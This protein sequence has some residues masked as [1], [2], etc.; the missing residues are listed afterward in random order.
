MVVAHG[1]FH[2]DGAM[3]E[4]MF[5]LI[6][7]P[8]TYDARLSTIG[9]TEGYQPRGWWSLVPINTNY[10]DM[11]PSNRALKCDIKSPCLVDDGVTTEKY[12]R[13]VDHEEWVNTKIYQYQEGTST[14]PLFMQAEIYVKGPK[15]TDFTPLNAS[16]LVGSSKIKR[17]GV[18]SWLD[19]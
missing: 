5:D 11:N 18:G 13:W 9:L 10:G 17:E 8:V 19:D 1:S 4:L 7:M 16:H 3:K 2:S 6:S 15:D 14:P 12:I